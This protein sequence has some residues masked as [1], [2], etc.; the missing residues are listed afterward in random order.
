MSTH[1]TL[2]RLPRFGWATEGPDGEL[3]AVRRDGEA[4]TPTAGGLVG[5]AEAARRIGVRPPNFV[6][7]WAARPDFP[8]P[9]GELASGRVWRT[10]DV[11]AYARDR[12]DRPSEARM[13]EIARRLVWWQAPERTLARTR[14]P[15]RRREVQ[16]SGRR[17]RGHEKVPAG[18]GP[19]AAADGDR[20]VN[21]RL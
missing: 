6:R 16:A 14:S 15:S 20:S 11:D 9:L 1:P 2:R 7:D 8:A 12:R 5:T 10:A 18:V 4:T 13:I 19:M 21:R 17:A 3:L